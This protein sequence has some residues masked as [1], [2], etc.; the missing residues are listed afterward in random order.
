MG[1]GLAGRIGLVAWPIVG[2]GDRARVRLGVGG[3]VGLVVGDRDGL[4][5][6]PIVGLG[7]R[8]KV[9]LGVAG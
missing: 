4:V 5:A 8:A 3:T 6:G 1:L 2:L 9:V 7:D